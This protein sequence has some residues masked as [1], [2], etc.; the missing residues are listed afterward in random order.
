MRET[1][2]NVQSAYWHGVQ[3]RTLDT[4]TQMETPEGRGRQATFP[5]EISMALE[6]I[7]FE[8]RADATL[9]SLPPVRTGEYPKI[10]FG[11][12]LMITESGGVKIRIPSRRSS[13]S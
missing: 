9:Q 13:A 5:P 3:N 10:N 6:R 8:P 1:F 11:R 12:W 7:Q 4:E 2:R